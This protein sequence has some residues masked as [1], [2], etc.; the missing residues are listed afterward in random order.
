F[1]DAASEGDANAHGLP[2]RPGDDLAATR[3]VV[4]PTRDR[5]SPAMQ[6][7]LAAD[8]GFIRDIFWDDGMIRATG[9]EYNALVESPCFA[10]AT[11]PARTMTCFTCHAMHR[12]AD[13]R[14]PLREWADDQLTP[15][16]IGGAVCVR[17][18]DKTAEHSHHRAGSSG[19]VCENCH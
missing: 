19:S 14:R 5:E 15:A 6:R 18:H 3:F 8:A 11:E 9:R 4:Q 16:A 17:C 10:P 13:D 7:F 2:Y 1:A 12:A